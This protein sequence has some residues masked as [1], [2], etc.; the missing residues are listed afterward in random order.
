MD[1]DIVRY[2]PAGP[3]RPQSGGVGG[4]GRDGLQQTG[5]HAGRQASQYAGGVGRHLDMVVGGPT[6]GAAQPR[7]LRRRIQPGGGRDGRR[8]DPRHPERADRAVAHPARARELRRHPLCD[9][10][11]RPPVRGGPPDRA[12]LRRAQRS[13]PAAPR[14]RRRP[15]RRL[16]GRPQR[17]R[18]GPVV[19]AAARGGGQCRS[20]GGLGHGAGR[21]RTGPAGGRRHA[22][23][24]D[25]QRLGEPAPQADRECPAS[26]AGTPSRALR[27]IRVPGWPGPQVG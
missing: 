13:P 25:L 14:P 12:D 20:R 11:A 21:S 22:R 3:S 17:A 27:S 16:H 5:Q 2:R 26:W 6:S 19:G 15:D 24:L 7:D 4:V 18:G 23:R 8:S 1:P 10:R 9:A